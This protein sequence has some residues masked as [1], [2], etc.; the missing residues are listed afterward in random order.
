MTATTTLRAL[1]A[2]CEECDLLAQDDTPGDIDDLDAGQKQALADAL[3][4]LTWG[5]AIDELRTM[6]DTVE[7]LEA[8]RDALRAEVARLAADLPKV[9]ADRD[10]LSAWLSRIEGG[11]NPCDDA[12]T[13]RRWAYEA[14]T[15]G[16]E[17]SDG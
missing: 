2:A 16:R 7:A 1:A 8:E 9:R 12:A 13:L 17:V 15:L 5:H 11:D 10:R 6:A 3:P 14:V 4:G